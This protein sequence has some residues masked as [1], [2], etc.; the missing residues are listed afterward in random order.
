MITEKKMH[1]HRTNL[2]KLRESN[3]RPWTQRA[4]PL[5]GLC[6]TTIIPDVKKW[7]LDGAN[8]PIHCPLPLLRVERTQI[9]L[10]LKFRTQKRKSVINVIGNQFCPLNGWIYCSLFLFVQFWYIKKEKWMTESVTDSNHNANKGFLK[11]QHLREKNIKILW[12]IFHENRHS[13]LHVSNGVLLVTA[14]PTGHWTQSWF[15]VKLTTVSVDE[16]F[17]CLQ[18]VLSVCVSLFSHRVEYIVRNTKIYQYTKYTLIHIKR[19]IAGE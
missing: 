4:G 16:N 2:F 7:W 17:A 8:F 6:L 3:L 13:Y 5:I 19:E 9:L 18:S 15:R 10:G 12:I 11:I 1:A 14:F